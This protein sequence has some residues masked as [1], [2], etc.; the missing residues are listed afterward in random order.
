MEGS[1]TYFELRYDSNYSRTIDT[2]EVL[3][4]ISSLD[5]LVRVDKIQ[6]KN[7][8]ELPWGIVTLIMASEKGNYSYDKGEYFE[9]IN[10]IEMILKDDSNSFDHYLGIG[11]R[12]AKNLNWELM[13]CDDDTILIKNE[14]GAA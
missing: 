13:D 9:K 5:E 4:Y 6:Y 7:K 2:E 12:I 14:K 1:Y 8:P 10:L 3:D 11:E